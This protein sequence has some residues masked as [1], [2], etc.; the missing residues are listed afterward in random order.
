MLEIDSSFPA[1]NVVE[2]LRR[3][4]R[5]ARTLGFHV[6]QEVLSGPQPAWCEF[7]GKKWLFLDASQPARDQ[8]ES[9]EVALESYLATIR[10]GS[11]LGQTEPA[12]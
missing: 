9:I 2:R 5:E 12:C 8:I 1:E 4:I 11:A 3:K 10:P 6:R 7:G